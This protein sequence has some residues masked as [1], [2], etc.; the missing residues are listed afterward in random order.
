MPARAASAPTPL[1]ARALAAGREAAARLL[2]R[3]LRHVFPFGRIVVRRGLARARVA[4][5][6]AVVLARLRDAVAFLRRRAL[7]RGAR[8]GGEGSRDEP[9]QGGSDQQAR[10]FHGGSFEVSGAVESYHRAAAGLNSRGRSPPPSRGRSRPPISAAP[11]APS[12]FGGPMSI[13]L[14]HEPLPGIDALLEPFLR[15]S[16][17]RPAPPRAIRVDVR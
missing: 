11:A 2:A 6:A 12:T 16:G 17:E 14:R 13:L 4:R 1:L 3:A 7:L 8:L 9:G 10:R 15:P 5:R